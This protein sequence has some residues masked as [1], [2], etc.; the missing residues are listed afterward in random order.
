MQGLLDLE[1]TLS[2]DSKAVGK[3]VQANPE[4]IASFFFMLFV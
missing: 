4:I 2:S 3:R 1:A